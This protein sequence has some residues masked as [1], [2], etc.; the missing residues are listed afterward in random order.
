MNNEN[1]EAVNDIFQPDPA[2]DYYIPWHSLHHVQAK[3]SEA[4][5]LMTD[6][7]ITNVAVD[8]QLREILDLA[9]DKLIEVVQKLEHD[10]E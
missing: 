3:I 4:L 10:E 6:A 5:K 2:W 9:S 8:E 7:E 1:S